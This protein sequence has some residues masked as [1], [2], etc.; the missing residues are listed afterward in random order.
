MMDWIRGAAVNRLSAT[1]WGGG[2]RSILQCL[3]LRS[4]SFSEWMSLHR[5]PNHVSHSF[6]PYLGGAGRLEWA[7]V[8]YLF[9]FPRSV[10]L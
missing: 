6:P 10:R 1:Q 4:Q 5:E 3:A 7:T 8:G 2:E 9:P